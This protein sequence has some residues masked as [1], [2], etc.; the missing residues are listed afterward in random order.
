MTDTS[1][2]KQTIKRYSKQINNTIYIIE[3]TFIA[4][5]LMD[6]DITIDKI[7]GS[8]T[9]LYFGSEKDFDEFLGLLGITKEDVEK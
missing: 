5:K 4:D 9:K 2:N 6:V 3:Y 1:L 8:N 7:G